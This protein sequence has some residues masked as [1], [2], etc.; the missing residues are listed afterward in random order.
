MADENNV[1]LDYDEVAN[2]DNEK[3]EKAK[4]QFQDTAYTLM[5]DV[6][7]GVGEIQ[8]YKYAL[9]D[10]SAIGKA[11]RGEPGYK[12][13]TPIEALGYVGLTGLG[14][15]GMTPI[16]GPYFRKAAQGIR[17]LMPKRARRSDPINREVRETVMNDPTFRTFVEGLP[18]YRQRP[19]S[20][21]DNI[22]EFLFLS[23]ERRNE[24]IDQTIGAQRAITGSVKQTPLMTEQS[25][26]KIEGD[27]EASKIKNN[28]SLVVQA[29]PLSFGKTKRQSQANASSVQSFIGSP[30]WDYVKAKGN[31]FATPKEWMGFMKGSLSKGVKAEELDDAGLILFDDKRN[32]IGGDLFK[33]NQ[34]DPRVKISKADVLAVL[35]TNPAYKLQV[36]NYSFPLNQVEISNIEKTFKPLSDDTMRLLNERILETPL[37]QRQPLKNLIV[38][39]TADQKNLTSISQKFSASKKQLEQVVDTKRRLTELLPS[40]KDNEKLIVRNLISDYNK[41]EAL[42]TKGLLRTNLPKHKSVFND[43][44]FNY[45]EKVIYLNESIPGNESAK[46]VYSS[47]FNDPNP[48]AHVRYDQRGVDAYGDTF[49]IGE[50][51][52]DPHQ[53]IAKQLSRYDGDKPLV[54]NNPFGN[55]IFNNKTKREIKEK[56][57]AINDLTK[58]ANERP[59]SPPEFDELKKLQK[60]RKILEKN[61]QVRPSLIDAREYQMTYRSGGSDKTY[62][63]FPLGK[64]NTWVK[65]SLKSIIA[66][67]QNK[68]VRY[69]AIGGADNYNFGAAGF[70]KKLEQFY[71][72]SGDALGAYSKVPGSSK[73]LPDGKNIG[74]YR[75]YE[76]GNIEG[77]AVVPKAMQDIAKEINAKVVVKKVMKSDITKPY[78][79]TDGDGKIVNAF[80]TKADRDE[81]LKTDINNFYRPLD[82]D[83]PSNYNVSVVLDLAG[84]KKGKMKAYKLG[85]L[86]QVKREYF[87]PLF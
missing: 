41:Y 65:A 17:A 47:H 23:D 32:P 44:G 6:T 40:L 73:K 7:P 45:Q 31:E 11:A 53:S 63:Y 77:T 26:K 42:A 68:G 64:E 62:D 12:D 22:R 39:I 50:I 74:K 70:K 2:L 86:V 33:L 28:K 34:S 71:G 83:D 81:F 4:K 72:L 78:K 55:K 15:A 84:S 18:E 35:E 66:D 80:K 58:K 69:I 37:N 57:D 60:E 27:F 13:M 3:L 79:I 10:A 82:L 25:V 48:I 16:V 75:N 61:F 38:S 29:E 52:S 20:R 19:E 8:S 54:R 67:A 87:A 85:G 9:E 46:K 24:L 5:R 21:N 51:Q 49:Y 14:I 30:A 1:I 59:L 43:G 76:T 56:I 36:K